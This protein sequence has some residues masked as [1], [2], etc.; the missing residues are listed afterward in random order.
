MFKK[1]KCPVNRL[2]IGTLCYIP[3]ESI[4]EDNIEPDKD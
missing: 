3:E 1:Y 2:S 4:K